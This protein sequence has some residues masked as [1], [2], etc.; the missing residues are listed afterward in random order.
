MVRQTVFLFIRALIFGLLINT[1]LQLISE[2][3]PNQQNV[4]APQQIHDQAIQSSSETK[5]NILEQADR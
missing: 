3:P 1:G 4:A 5:T 2:P